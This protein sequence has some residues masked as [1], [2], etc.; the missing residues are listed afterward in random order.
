[1]RMHFGY[2]VLAAIAATSAAIAQTDT[3]GANAHLVVSQSVNEAGTI[4]LPKVPGVVTYDNVTNFTGFGYANGG[5][6]NLAGNT[7]TTLVADD[8]T[9]AGS[10][11]G[12]DITRFY[13]SVVN[14]N[15]AAVTARARVRFWNA[16]G[17]AGAPGSYYSNPG[18]IGFTFN[19]I[20]FGASSVSVFY[21]DLAANTF[22]MPS[23]TFWAGITFD[24]NTGGTGIT[25]AQLNNLGQGIFDPP[26]VGSSADVAFQTTA[27]GSFFTIANPAGQLF[28]FGGQPK[29]NFGWRFEAVP[30]PST[31]VA[32]ATGLFGVLGLRRRRR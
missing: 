5:A 25:A 30:E 11:G 1:M 16:D 29:A 17:T 31:Y 10:L 22:K 13:F 4:T 24:N 21:T 18:A 8:I 28:N 12:Q 7:I 3:T 23:G 6:A 15:A 14:F 9:P 2:F 32:I 19:P 26:V 27:A 20:L